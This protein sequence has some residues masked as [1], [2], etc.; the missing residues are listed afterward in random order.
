MCSDVRCQMYDVRQ[1]YIS[2]LLLAK[3]IRTSYICHRTF[4]AL[5]PKVC[6]KKNPPA[7][8]RGNH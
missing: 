6:L 3:D 2:K 5:Q 1:S 7:F 4:Y 8:A